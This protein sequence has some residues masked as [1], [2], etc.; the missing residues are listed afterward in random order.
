MFRKI[1]LF[2]LL[3]MKGDEKDMVAVYVALI[4]AGRRTYSQVPVTLKQQ[5]KEE[6]IAL[7]LSHLVE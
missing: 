3:C 2:F 4:V 5:V 7:D 1:Y 6:L